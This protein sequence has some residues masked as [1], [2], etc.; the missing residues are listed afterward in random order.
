[1]VGCEYVMRWWGGRKRNVVVQTG[2]VEGGAPRQSEAGSV[3][4]FW[5]S[6][7]STIIDNQYLHWFCSFWFAIF[8]ILKLA[9][10]IMHSFR[11][12]QHGLLL[13]T[14]MIS[15]LDYFENIWASFAV[16]CHIVNIGW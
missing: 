5:F 14:Q 4:R 6:V 16:M 13:T 8:V 15:R 11:E 1:M 12:Q 7:R 2:K 3:N 10:L 9:W